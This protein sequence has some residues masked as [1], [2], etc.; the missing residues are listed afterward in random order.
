[1]FT[2]E[3][4]HSS[5]VLPV[6]EPTHIDELPLWAQN[7]SSPPH[8]VSQSPHVST[9]ESRASQPVSRRSSQSAV[10]GAH[11]NLHSPA[12]QTLIP[13]AGFSGQALPHVPQCSREPKS[14]SSSVAPSQS[15]FLP[16]HVS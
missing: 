11:N 4:P 14:K 9:S 5:G 15:S 8:A 10:P 16:L 7:G 1:V 2:H 6:H 12:T 3:S 13:N